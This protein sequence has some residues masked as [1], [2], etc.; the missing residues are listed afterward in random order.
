MKAIKKFWATPLLSFGLWI[1]CTS[2]IFLIRSFYSFHINI[3]IG[4]IAFMLLTYWVRRKAVGSKEKIIHT[5][6]LLI[7]PVALSILAFF[8][9]III[10]SPGLI[11]APA[12]GVL[13]GYLLSRPSGKLV[14]IAIAL[15]PIFIGLWVYV[16]FADIWQEF[17]IYGTF[18]SGET[19]R[20]CPRFTFLKDSIAVGNDAFKGK[21]TVFFIWN[22]QCVYTPRYIP[23][24]KEKFETYADDQ[25]IDFYL[26]NVPLE[27]DT[28]GAD[29]AYLAAYDLEIENLTGPSNDEMYKLFGPGAYPQAMVLNPEGN[30]VFWGSITKIDR[31]LR[32]QLP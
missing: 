15:M 22:T 12:L 7:P 9:P 24:L 11:F 8:K 32:R 17:V 13:F 30:I 2:S 21:T 16:R 3:V 5:F 29:L 26:V 28:V 25:G 14:K 1:L 19:M 23:A 6:L 20:E 10:Y 27:G 31:T 4:L 18:R